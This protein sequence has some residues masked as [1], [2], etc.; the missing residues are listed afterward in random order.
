MILY[1][2]GCPKCKIL[3]KKLDDKKI[4]YEECGDIELMIRKGITFLPVLET[5]SGKLLDFSEAN[6]YVN[7]K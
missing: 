4:K 6:E 1:S 7:N 5:D 2:N 3:K